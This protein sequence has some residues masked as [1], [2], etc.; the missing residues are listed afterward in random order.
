MNLYALP[1]GSLHEKRLELLIKLTKM[2]S[3]ALKKAL[4]LYFV[5][6]YTSELA[7]GLV[8]LDKSTVK[9]AIARIGAVHEIVERIK[10]FDT[11]G[12]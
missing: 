6:G 9:K 3:A 7:A 2:R 4:H 12:R 10:E 1:R 5:N 8:D 11:Y